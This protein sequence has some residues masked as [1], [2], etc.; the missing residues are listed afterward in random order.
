MRRDKS[1]WVQVLIAAALVA[2]G[3]SG[4]R[5]AGTPV[6]TRAAVLEEACPRGRLAGPS[7]SLPVKEGRPVRI[8]EE[9]DT[10]HVQAQGYGMT[11]DRTG[12]RFIWSDPKRRFAPRLEV[13]FHRGMAVADSSPES[14]WNDAGPDVR[15]VDGPPP[16]LRGDRIVF[17]LQPGV[18]EHWTFEDQQAEQL[19]V[20]HEARNEIRV[21]FATDL[22]VEQD[23]RGLRFGPI[24]YGELLAYDAKGRTTVP[25]LRLEG[26]EIVLSLDPEWVHDATYPVTVDPTIAVGPTNLSAAAGDDIDALTAFDSVNNRYMIV[27]ANGGT[28]YRAIRNADGTAFAAPAAIALLTAGVETYATPAVA[29]SATDSKYVVVARGSLGA[30]KIVGCVLDALGA[31][32]SSS[33]SGVE[34]DILKNDGLPWIAW[35]ADDNNFMTVWEFSFSAGDG[36]IYRSATSINASNNVVFGAATVIDGAASDHRTPF[37]AYRVG[38]GGGG[39]IAST[40]THY[41]LAYINDDANNDVVLRSLDST[42]AT[43]ATLTLTNGGIT[44]PS[45]AFNAP[46]DQWLLVLSS[47]GATAVDI[48]GRIMSLDLNTTIVTTTTIQDA[49][50]S[51]AVQP[52]AAYSST[53]SAFYIDWQQ[54]AGTDDDVLGRMAFTDLSVL[55]AVLTLASGAADSNWAAVSYNSNS[56]NPSPAAAATAHGTALVTYSDNAGGN[57]D[58]FFAVV[59]LNTTPAPAGSLSPLNASTVSQ[60]VTLSWAEPTDPDSDHTLANQ[61]KFDV[62]LGTTNPPV[63]VVASDLTATSFTTLPLE[64]LTTYY[65]KV[66]AKDPWQGSTDSAVLSFTTDEV[67]GLNRTTITPVPGGLQAGVKYA[68]QR[69]VA[70]GGGRWWFVQSPDDASGMSAFYTANGTTWT[71]L[72][73]DGALDTDYSCAWEDGTYLYA[74]ASKF[75]SPAGG[76]NDDIVIARVNM[77]TTVVDTATIVITNPGGDLHKPAVCVGSTGTFWIADSNNVYSAAAWNGPYTAASPVVATGSARVLVPIDAGRVWLLFSDSATGDIRG[78]LFDGTTWGASVTISAAGLGTANDGQL[79]A[80]SATVDPLRNDVHLAFVKVAA[81]ESAKYQRWDNA[82]NAWSAAVNISTALALPD[83]VGITCFAP[84]D[85][86]WYYTVDHA[87]DADK[88]FVSKAW[89]GVSAPTAAANWDAWIEV[90]RTAASGTFRFGSS[91]FRSSASVMSVWWD[92]TDIQLV[93]AGPRVSIGTGAFSFADKAQWLPNQTAPTATDTVTVENV[94]R[95]P[96]PTATINL[97]RCLARTVRIPAGSALGQGANTLDVY[98]HFDNAGTFTGG[99]GTTR[100][101]STG[102]SPPNTQ[103]GWISTDADPF[104]HVEILKA[105]AGDLATTRTALTIGGN[106]TI[107]QGT[108]DLDPSTTQLSHTVSGNFAQSG[109]S[110]RF[111]SIGTTSDLTAHLTVTGSFTVTAGTFT[112]STAIMTQEI[113]AEGSVSIAAGWAYHGWFRLRGPPDDAGATIRTVGI[114]GKV[115]VLDV[116]LRDPEDIYDVSTAA[117]CEYIT[118]ANGELR[119][120]ALAMLTVANQIE[121]GFATTDSAAGELGT[122]RFDGDGASAN[123]RFTVVGTVS[124]YR[125]GWPATS[126]NDGTFDITGGTLSI[127]LSPGGF[128]GD[129]VFDNTDTLANASPILKLEGGTIQLAAGWLV[130]DA[131]PGS[132]LTFSASAGTV[133]LNGAAAQLI[134]HAPEAE[135]LVGQGTALF[136]LTINNSAVDD[137]ANPVTLAVDLTAKNV[138][139]ITDGRLRIGGPRIL[140]LSGAVAHSVAA[141]GK[142]DLEPSGASAATLRLAH[143]GSMSV[144]GLLEALRASGASASSVIEIPGADGAGWFM[145]VSGTIDAKYFTFTDLGAA[146]I[147]VSDGGTI[148]R[149]HEG[150]LTKEAALTGPCLDL[151]AVTGVNRSKIPYTLSNLTF[152][153][154]SGENAKAG[155]G[156]PMVSFLGGGG[157]RWGESFDTDPL[158]NELGI[159]SEGRILW[160]SAQ[161]QNFDTGATY[162]TVEAALSAALANQRIRPLRP[163][164]LSDLVEFPVDAILERFVLAPQTG[165]AVDGG[166]SLLGSLQNCVILRGGADF[167]RLRNCTVF[168]P[169]ASTPTTTNCVA[170]NTVFEEAAPGLT[171]DVN[172]LKSAAATLFVD[173]AGLDFHLAADD[174]GTTAGT[175]V[176]W[177]GLSEDI[178]GHARTGNWDRGVDEFY[179]T[180]VQKLAVDT[181]YISRF[182]WIGGSRGSASAANGFAYLTSMSGSTTAA[183]NNTLYVVNL[184]TMAVVAQTQAVGPIVSMAFWVDVSNTGPAWRT[185]IWLVVDTDSDGYG[186]A[187]QL[188]VDKG[189]GGL[190]HPDQTVANADPTLRRFGDVAVGARYVYRPTAVAT[191]YRIRWITRVTVPADGADDDTS[192]VYNS[193]AG[194]NKAKWNRI[195]FSAYKTTATTG[196][197][198]FKVNADPYDT[199]TA[200][201]PDNQAFGETM[202]QILPGDA[203]WY[204]FDFRAPLTF[205]WASGFQELFVPVSENTTPAQTVL[206]RYSMPGTTAPAASRNWQ[207]TEEAAPVDENRFGATLDNGNTNATCVYGLSDGTVI[208]NRGVDSASGSGGLRWA[209]RLKDGAANPVSPVLGPQRFWP[210]AFALVAYDGG[211]NKIWSVNGT[212]SRNGCLASTG[213]KLDLITPLNEV[214]VAGTQDLDWPMACVGKPIQKIWVRSTKIY[215]GTD[216]GYVYGRTWNRDGSS[217]ATG[218]ESL[219]AGYPYMIPGARITWIFVHPTAGVLVGTD[220]GGLYRFAP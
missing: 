2:W 151:S 166:A 160:L 113:N 178:E 77:S 42:G 91:N 210:N 133:E 104:N 48:T 126:Q 3:S 118:I 164:V 162:G 103:G 157:A 192:V 88:V 14:P 22:A 146:G 176:G 18:E 27:W 127:T 135:S 171:T 182:H 40:L 208:Y 38:D 131:D 204:N 8:L 5:D 201:A 30:G 214:S 60:P 79:S 114:S 53:N 217:T 137:S 10:V 140:T 173:A 181:G 16:V 136:N 134:T 125:V 46:S 71:T 168:D 101:R 111:D 84:D 177:V 128:K 169:S 9:R 43:V 68:N 183:N 155:M 206:V 94:N 167:V 67:G 93:L 150:T 80:F 26:R 218:D 139:T 141:A 55:G 74:V 122:I 98:G 25:Q 211:V 142:L 52:F 50:A 87:S 188:V 4:I 75:D 110:L 185:W 120:P 58:V 132:S 130:Q 175:P 19:F 102:T 29:F 191:D 47:T 92:G 78:R 112:G 23:E 15:A 89:Y 59:N 200:S 124:G 213:L 189:D 72:D 66:R 17:R 172:N 154:T 31:G 161:I 82:G 65:W 105:A 1:T 81:G 115:R 76:N 196:G 119:V 11:F 212:D 152:A 21:P 215:F 107:T 197:A 7:P 163:V 28:I 194:T 61:L 51:N 39:T 116:Q 69:K 100:F 106:L 165:L 95:S 54:G 207:A 143:G 96:A 156:T 97:T 198:L 34:V 195:F 37:I 193:P 202:W 129:F 147:A 186:D 49:G 180:G 199:N 83:S 159:A 174:A 187:I 12:A 24:A 64:P 149:L 184:S 44:G 121:A 190:T 123:R 57:F 148:L 73:L 45:L 205:T 62:L 56:T 70:Y 219:I 153:G 108:L 209:A 6:E 20:L 138:L 158:E 41:G 220:T 85:Q 99:T 13:R 203:S 33:L 63:P 109:G 36:D 145:T 35:N 144:S 179:S 216:R 32:L 90:E 170:Y 117:T 86:M